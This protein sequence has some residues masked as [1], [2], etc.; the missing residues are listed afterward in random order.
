MVYHRILNIVP[1]AMQWELVVYSGH[2]FIFYFNFIGVQLIY[3]AESVPVVQHSD[4]V[5]HPNEFTLC[6]ILFSYRLSQNIDY[7]FLYCTVGPCW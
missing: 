5:I 6:W 2:T 3:N 4:S 7:S 1:C